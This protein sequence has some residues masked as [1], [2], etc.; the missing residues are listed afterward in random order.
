[1]G[2]DDV[3]ELLRKNYHLERRPDYHEGSF[4]V[5]SGNFI[6]TIQEAMPSIDSRVLTTASL[7]QRESGLEPI[8]KEVEINPELKSALR[9]AGYNAMPAELK[10]KAY[11]LLMSLQIDAYVGLVN[12]E[13]FILEVPKKT[14][15]TWKENGKDVA[16]LV[17]VKSFE[18]WQQYGCILLETGV[19]QF[20]SYIQVL[21]EKVLVCNGFIV[22]PGVSVNLQR[23][24]SDPAV[25]AQIYA[26]AQFI[27]SDFSSQGIASYAVEHAT[28]DAK[29]FEPFFSEI[30]K[31]LRGLGVN[32]RI[33]LRT[34]RELTSCAEYAV[35]LATAY[36]QIHPARA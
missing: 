5:I 6:Q 31:A 11:Q 25:G 33:R 27:N 17:A 9:A 15:L 24:E 18:A 14:G 3:L 19:T 2:L 32:E 23:A 8:I 26:V 13:E 35:M 10:A 7:Q 30:S 22:P 28:A 20:S 1:M 34:Y 16:G 29:A 21:K 36:A 4:A 12:G